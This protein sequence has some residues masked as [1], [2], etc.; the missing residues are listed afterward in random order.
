MNVLYFFYEDKNRYQMKNIL[1]NPRKVFCRNTH[2]LQ[3]SAVSFFY[4]KAVITKRKYIKL[5][6]TEYWPR[7]L[8]VA[9]EFQTRFNIS[10]LEE[11]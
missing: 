1:Y 4:I 5:T 10:V 11:I 9:Q 2:Y 6:W 7:Y 3:S 8:Y